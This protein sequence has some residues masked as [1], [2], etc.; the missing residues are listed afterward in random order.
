MVILSLSWIVER[1]ESTTDSDLQHQIRAAV[2]DLQWVVGQILQTSTI[3]NTSPKRPL[4]D[5]DDTVLPPG[6]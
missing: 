4:E 5:G 6:K 1:M 3:K 2:E